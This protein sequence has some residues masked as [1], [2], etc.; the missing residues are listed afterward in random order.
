MSFSMD[1]KSELEGVLPNARHCQLA[2]LSALNSFGNK[3]AD[4]T[5]PAGRKIFTLQKKASMINRYVETILKNS[6]CKR[7]YVRGAFLCVGSMTD[8]AKG[9]DLEFVCDEEEKAEFLL[10]IISE[11]E[12]DARITKRKN[13]YVLYVKD[14]Q[15]VVDTLNV[16]GARNSLMELETL[17]VEKDF[18]NLVNRKVNCEAANIIKAANASAK[19]IND[20]RRIEQ[21]MG[22]DKLPLVLKEVALIRLEFPDISMTELGE[23]LN[24]PVGKSGVNHRLRRLSEIADAIQES[25]SK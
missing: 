7:A 22:L 3:I 19:Q 17:R 6:C 16:M 14:A 25:D 5:T 4:E 15:G 21:Y 2:E 8:P 23:K 18:R 12:I 10:K 20:I 11:F 1:V 9:Y 24:P 13:S